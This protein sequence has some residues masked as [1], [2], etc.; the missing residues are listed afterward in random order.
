MAAVRN[1]FTFND[2][3]YG[4]F[5]SALVSIDS[6][7]TGTQVGTIGSAGGPVDMTQNLTQ[8]VIGDGAQFYVW[9][10]TT[11][12]TQSSYAIGN[13][14]A[15]VDQRVVFPL[16]GT[17]GFQWTSLGDAR[18]LDPLDFASAEGSPDQLITVIANFRELLLL[19][20]YTGEVWHSVGG[21]T[22]FERSPSEYL[23]VGCAAARSAVVVGDTPVWLAQSQ[24]GRAQ[25]CAGRGQRISTRAIEERFEGL[26]VTQ[27]RAYTY[28]D[29][30]HNFY[31]LNVPNVDT[32]LTYD[33]TFKQWHERAEGS[34]PYTQWRPTCHAFAY[35]MHYF[36][37]DDGVI[38]ISDPT[39]NTF[40]GSVKCRDR[41]SPVLSTPDRRIKSFPSVDILAERGTGG[42]VMIRWS[43]DNGYTWGNWHYDSAGA[44]GKFRD[45]MRFMRTGSARDRV[46]Q[47]RMTDNAPFFP[48]DVN[49]D[50]R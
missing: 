24:D 2:V 16:R 42:T 21:A 39:V 18:V 11:L 7:G 13:S 43:D 14:L 6:S 36:G 25:V 40:A 47:I 4:V 10:G 15:F 45:R 34:S 5:G 44:V 33:T 22:V 35:G 23:Q 1:I 48:V 3:L 26:D 20:E 41:I 12:T 50:M 8:L 17:Q 46:Y 29:G 30:G 9:D 38:Y 32:T 19:G 31:C 37:A 28:S 49:V 27:A